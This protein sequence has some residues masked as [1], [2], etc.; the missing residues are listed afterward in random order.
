MSEAGRRSGSV[1]RALVAP[2]AVLMSLFARE[3]SGSFLGLLPSG[4][5]SY[6]HSHLADVLHGATFGSAG[7]AETVMQAPPFVFFTSLHQ[8]AQLT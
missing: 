7:P 6:L 3:H 8:L 5:L 1:T 4:G 2:L